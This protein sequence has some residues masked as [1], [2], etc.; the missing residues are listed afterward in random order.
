MIAT[1]PYF[2]DATGLETARNANAINK[3]IE[4]VIS[5]SAIQPLVRSSPP[6][7]GETAVN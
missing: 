2:H 1:T 6:M 3:I 4:R 5:P 7:V